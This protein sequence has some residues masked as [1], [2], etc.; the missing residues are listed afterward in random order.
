MVFPIPETLPYEVDP[1]FWGK[2]LN[3]AKEGLIETEV[4]ADITMWLVNSQFRQYKG[5]QLWDEFREWYEGWTEATFKIAHREAL[6]LVR[7]QLLLHG[8]QVRP[9]KGG[10]SYAKVLAELLSKNQP[11]ERTKEVQEEAERLKLGYTDINQR[12]RFDEMIIRMK[13]HFET[14]E[15]RQKYLT[16]WRNTTFPQVIRKYPD[17][18]L[19][20]QLEKLFETLRTL[21][22]G[23]VDSYQSE[24]MLRDQIINACREV[25]ECNFVL[26]R[27][28]STYEGLCA[29]LRN[30][31]G[32]AERMRTTNTYF[33]DQ[34]TNNLLGTE[35]YWTDP[36]NCSNSK[37]ISLK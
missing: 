23:L 14:E 4:N 36:I 35:I 34:M 33:A 5:Q 9:A 21:Q 16:E 32:Q 10:N 24:L 12:L 25:P 37:R 28:A 18:T 17:K 6:K 8:F 7:N 15:R 22:Y 26:L 31:I 1:A 19:S 20:E 2:Q 13:A 27:P 29:D 11:D 3:P 30:A